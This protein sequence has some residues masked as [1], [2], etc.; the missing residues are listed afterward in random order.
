MIHFLS[1]MWL[2]TIFLKKF[3]PQCT[4]AI[5]L[6]NSFS[7]FFFYLLLMYA[8]IYC[9]IHIME[10]KGNVSYTFCLI[11]EEDYILI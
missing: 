5:F 8:K 7:I 11:F 6:E 9:I 10:N 4:K 2:H 3:F 1:F